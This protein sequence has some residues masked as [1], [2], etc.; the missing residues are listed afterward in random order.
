MTTQEWTGVWVSD[1]P[2]D[3]NEGANGDRIFEMAIDNAEF[4]R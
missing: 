1:V 4:A 3:G 2:L